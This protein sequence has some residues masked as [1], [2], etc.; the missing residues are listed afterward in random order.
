MLPI[1]RGF[2][3]HVF[4]P[5]IC[6]PLDHIL[7]TIDLGIRE[8]NIGIVIQ[9]IRKDNKKEKEFISL[10]KHNISNLDTS[11]LLNP[12]DLEVCVN[13][14]TGIFENIWKKELHY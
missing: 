10:I 8:E 3:K 12:N 11:F 7:I 9:S 5:K 2:N 1:N 4:Y 14:L 13:K 6:K